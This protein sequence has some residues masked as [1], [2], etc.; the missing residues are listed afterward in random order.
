[1]IHSLYLRMFFLGLPGLYLA[2]WLSRFSLSMVNAMPYYYGMLMTAFSLFC[3]MLLG[4]TLYPTF[5]RFIHKNCVLLLLFE[6]TFLLIG[7]I[8]NWMDAGITTKW[9]LIYYFIGL[10]SLGCALSLCMQFDMRK[11]RNMLLYSFVIGS[12]L[13][14]FI[15]V[16]YFEQSQPDLFL[17]IPVMIIIIAAYTVANK[18][19]KFSRIAVNLLIS[20]IN[21]L[22]IFIM[23]TKEQPSVHYLTDLGY[24]R[25]QKNPDNSINVI[26]HQKKI[27]QNIN[28]IKNINSTDVFAFQLQVNKEN[29]KVLYIGYPGSFT[30]HAIR[31]SRL[32]AQMDTFFW[33]VNLPANYLKQTFPHYKFYISEWDIFNNFKQTKYDLIVIEH[34]PYESISSCRVFIHYTKRLLNDPDGVLAFPE[35]LIRK[36]DGQYIKMSAK[37]PLVM[38]MGANSTE[39]HTELEERSLKYVK[40]FMK[41]PENAVGSQ[42]IPGNMICNFDATDTLNTSQNDKFEGPLSPAIVRILTWVLLGI[43][44]VF[45]IFKSR[46]RNNQNSFFAFESGFTF[47]IITFFS[48]MLLSELRLVYPFFSPALF[49]ISVI[50]LLPVKNAKFNYFCQFML[51][52]L[53]MYMTSINFVRRF[54]PVH[55]LPVLLPLSYLALAK[56][57][58]YCK[59]GIKGNENCLQ[60]IFFTI[61]VLLTVM[62]LFFAKNNNLYPVLIYIAITTRLLYYFKI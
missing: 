18:K 50:L 9:Q 15:G 3:G 33:D 51:L 32:V 4:F 19:I 47:S 13:S 12:V 49:G 20:A 1:M 27:L 25:M 46:F 43:Y 59:I 17:G 44:M 40:K 7:H 10:A 45:R 30:P 16:K 41:I 21:I 6:F 23:H 55:V 5:K 24:V 56:T 38:I 22:L 26:D 57:L 28:D 62:L 31:R 58:N 39:K 61:G 53:L 14:F 48:L 34:L 35:H 2:L 42:N 52:L 8:F 60:N 37:S 54:P 36:Y 11:E 29:L